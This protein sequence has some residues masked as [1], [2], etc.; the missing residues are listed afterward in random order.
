MEG[1][2]L[3]SL[4]TAEHQFKEVFKNRLG[5]RVL[6]EFERLFRSNFIRESDFKRIA[7]LGFNCLRIPFNYR[8]LEGSPYQYNEEGIRYLDRAIR[9]AEKVS[10]K[11]ILDLHAAPGCQNC[12]WH[13]DSCGKADLW[14]NKNNQKRTIAIWEI[15]ADRYKDKDIIAGY[16]V[17]NEP[18]VRNTKLLNSFYHRL[19]KHIRK[20][21][22]NHILFVE[23]NMW[24]TDI[25]CLDAFKDDNL[26]LSVHSY[27][28]LEFT[29]NYIPQIRYPICSRNGNFNKTNIRKRHQSYKKISEKTKRP[30][31]VGEFGVNDRQG[32]YGEDKWLLDALRV[33][34]E[35][36]FHWTYWTYKAVKN[37]IFPD[38]IFSYMDNP[39]WVSRHGFKMGW[40]NYA[41]VWK[42]NKHKMA[43]S[44]RTE[45]FRKNKTL[46]N[47][48]KKFL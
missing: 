37:G 2:L 5:K 26:V 48:L 34:E 36:D 43:Q 11:V 28:P 12:D 47:V 3:H 44:W 22:R 42:E 38:G 27:E 31:F 21:D 13:S 8:L 41:D 9:W 35:M 1:Y 14:T 40:D 39:V 23:G 33:Y 4:N 18:V 24:S 19:I 45:E 6:E 29:F 17:L 15:L 25:A 7:S 16:N 30:I 46:I 32:F 20:I 10:L